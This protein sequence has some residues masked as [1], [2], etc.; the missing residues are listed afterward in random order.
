MHVMCVCASCKY[1]IR[2]YC[3]PRWLDFFFSY[4]MRCIGWVGVRMVRPDVSL[5]PKSEALP[6]LEN[7]PLDFCSSECETVF[8]SNDM[9]LIRS[10]TFCVGAENRKDI[11]H[12]KKI[13][14][15]F[16]YESIEYS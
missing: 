15:R 12:K 1:N 2:D 4:L 14:I 11:P 6:C 7:G 13:H 3:L 10:Y 5:Y 8:L 16:V 9:S